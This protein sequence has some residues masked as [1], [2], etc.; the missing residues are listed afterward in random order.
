MMLLAKR[1]YNNFF[2]NLFDDSFFM[3]PAANSNPQAMKTDVIEKD[4]N[5]L[6]E[7]ELPGYK[8][9]EIKVDLKEGYLTISANKVEE[10]EEKDENQ[11]VVR[12]ERFSGSCKRSFYVGENLSEE[13]IKA[14]YN[15]GILHLTLPKEK[16]AVKEEPKAITIE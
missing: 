13:D 11:K 8:K 2:N 4:G 15:D 16:E 7:V 9:E 10:T 12:K 14:K 3:N 1:D 5:Y 6:V